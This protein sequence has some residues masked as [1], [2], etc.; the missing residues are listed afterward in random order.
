[1]PA[2]RPLSAR[3]IILSAL[4]GSPRGLRADLLVHFATLFGIAEGTSRV[5]LTRMS[6]SGEITQESGRYRLAGRLDERRRRQDGSR[7]AAEVEWSGDWEMFVVQA[8]QRDHQARYALRAAGSRLLLAELREGVW[9]RPANLIRE[10]GSEDLAV[11]AAQCEAFT[12]RPHTPGAE[13]TARLWPLGDW[14]AAAVALEAR[15][16]AGLADLRE[17]GG[18]GLAEAFVLSADTLRLLLDDPLLPATLLPPDWPG[19]ALR[20]AFEEFDRLWQEIFLSWA[21]D[22]RRAAVR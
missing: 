3:S 10:P 9:I 21:R 4:M 12:M 7:F 13:L 2:S 1:M 14:A 15:L 19:P 5:A 6:Q 17:R 8:P 16:R 22:F 18:D 20:A 11:V